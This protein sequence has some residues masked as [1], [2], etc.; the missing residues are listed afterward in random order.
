MLK[1]LA[2]ATLAAASVLAAAPAVLACDDEAS[3]PQ[4]AQATPATPKALEVDQLAALMEQSV[5]SK[6]ALFIFDVNT[7]KDPRTGTEVYYLIMEFVAG[8]TA[9]GLLRSHIKAGKGPL[10]EAEA[11][12]I[13]IAATKGLA[14]A[15]EEN[16]VHRD[17]KPDNIMLTRKGQVKIADFGLARATSEDMEL[18]KAGQIL[19]T[20]AYMSPE[21]CL[22][23]RVDHR[24]DLFSAGVIL[25]QLLTGDKPF[26]GSLTC[27]MTPLSPLF[28]F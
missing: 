2:A 4:T 13:V 20:P 17:I 11:L 10:S 28:M 23:E 25:Y 9:G 27:V 24:S 16:I 5:K 18:T 12:D 7:E 8:E 1:T 21:Q 26:T 3:T 6:S 19:G 15:H 22:G 14:A